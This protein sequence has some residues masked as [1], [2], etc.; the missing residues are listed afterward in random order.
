MAGTPGALSHCPVS[1]SHHMSLCIPVWPLQA[2]HPAAAAAAA[3]TGAAL[4]EAM[5]MHGRSHPTV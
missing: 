2:T 1:P 3:G 4:D 5:N